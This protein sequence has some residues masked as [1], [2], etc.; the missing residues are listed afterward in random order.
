MLAAHLDT[1]FT[2]GTD[3]SVKK[4][5]DRYYA[6]SII[7]DA[8]GLAA[9]LQVLRTMNKMQIETVGAGGRRL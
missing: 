8:R 5:N 1:V 7:D 6:P 9:L 4:Q 3:V 2:E